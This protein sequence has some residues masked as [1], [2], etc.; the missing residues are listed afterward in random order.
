MSF[1]KCPEC[2]ET[3]FYEGDYKHRTFD[4]G[5]QSQYDTRTK[6]C[7]SNDRRAAGAG[8]PISI[9]HE[10]AR[11]RLALLDAA[12]AADAIAAD[13]T[14]Q[15]HENE[16]AERC[17]D[18]ARQMREFA[19]HSGVGSPVGFAR[20]GKRAGTALMTIIRKARPW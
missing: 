18:L 2:Q 15:G 8:V 7:R 5:F 4:C 20:Q 6:P 12:Q 14:A 3:N 17:R 10:V 19:G 13:M 16:F 9:P 11:Y 1:E